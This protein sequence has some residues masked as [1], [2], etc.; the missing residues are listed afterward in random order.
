MGEESTLH[1]PI[2]PYPPCSGVGSQA[3]HPRKH[4]MRVEILAPHSSSAAPK[5]SA[6]QLREVIN[7][8]N[9]AP[10][11][12]GLQGQPGCLL[13]IAVLGA[14]FSTLGSTTPATSQRLVR[15]L[16]DCTNGFLLGGRGLGLQLGGRGRRSL[17]T[18][19]HFPPRSSSP[20]ELQANQR[21]D[22]KVVTSE[23]SN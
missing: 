6:P 16:P 9:T 18:G 5:G 21:L 2:R 8:K 17:Q 20:R 22:S 23:A 7:H 11:F 12:Q 1:T 19:R 3:K 14:A 15:S 10:E 4:R 13:S